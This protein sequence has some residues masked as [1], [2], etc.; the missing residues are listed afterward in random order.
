MEDCCNWASLIPRPTWFSH[1]GLGTMLSLSM[2]ISSLLFHYNNWIDYGNCRS[3][4]QLHWRGCSVGGRGKW[5]YGES[6]GVPWWGV[7]NSLWW[8]YI[9]EPNWNPNCMQATFWFGFIRWVWACYNT[10]AKYDIIYLLPLGFRAIN[11]FYG[12]GDGPVVDVTCIGTE[13][14]LNECT[15]SN[16]TVCSHSQDGGAICPGMLVHH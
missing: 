7:G 1:V 3:W 6:G 13:N 12:E 11:G 8:P 5:V 10:F 2:D 4:E 16:Q 14:R 15:I 9:L